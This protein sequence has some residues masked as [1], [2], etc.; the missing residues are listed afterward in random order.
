[1]TTRR[2]CKPS[3]FSSKQNC[4][5][6]RPWATY[7]ARSSRSPASCNSKTYRPAARSP[8]QQ[9]HRGT[10]I[11]TDE[12]DWISHLCL[13]VFIGGSSVICCYNNS[14]QRSVVKLL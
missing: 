10:Q 11:N 8:H 12:N 5:R 6:P 13:S 1:M 9:N 4:P 14:P 3:K 7:G 2:S